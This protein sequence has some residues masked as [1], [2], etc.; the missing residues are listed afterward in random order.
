MTPLAAGLSERPAAAPPAVVYAAENHNDAASLL[1]RAVADAMRA[2]R[3]RPGSAGGAVHCR[4]T[5]DVGH[6][7]LRLAFDVLADRPGDRAG[8]VS[9][10][11]HRLR[12]LPVLR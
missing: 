5:S 6:G 8:D 7:R 9:W 4:R 3:P 1:A 10:V 11:L 12:E 2:D